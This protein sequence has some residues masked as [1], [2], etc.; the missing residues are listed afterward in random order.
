MSE[1]M[2]PI[3]A[4]RRAGPRSVGAHLLRRER[5]G[6]G[7]QSTVARSVGMSDPASPAVPGPPLIRSRQVARLDWE[8]VEINGMWGSTEPAAELRDAGRP[9]AAS[10]VA[11]APF[12]WPGRRRRGGVGLLPHPVHELE[13]EGAAI[14]VPLPPRPSP[15]AASLGSSSSE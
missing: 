8:S 5:D 13:G 2:S 4:T 10:A 3:F 1:S 15:V 7:A 14:V 9:C 12:V 6:Q 11:R